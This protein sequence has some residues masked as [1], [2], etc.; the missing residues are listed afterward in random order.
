M[1]DIRD[2]WVYLEN[3]LL[4]ICRKYNARLSFDIACEAVIAEALQRVG[5]SL[6]G[7]HCFDNICRYDVTECGDPDLEP[8]KWWVTQQLQRALTA[9][10]VCLSYA[11]R[12]KYL[13]SRTALV[14]VVV[15]DM[16]K[17][18]LG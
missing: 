10:Q 15:R 18:E 14:L 4:P 1:L 5:I 17:R 13:A 12:V 6:T 7:K 9:H 2:I 3:E 11:E 8:I 16:D